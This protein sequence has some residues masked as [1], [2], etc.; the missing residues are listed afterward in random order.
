MTT[1]TS[2]II[3]AFGGVSKLAK[4]L[5]HANVTT[6]DGWKR[7]GR[8]PHWRRLEIVD[9]AKREGVELPQSF[10]EVA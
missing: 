8:I 7:K 3:N 4:A 5:G 6:V 9:A 1:T 10:S 2:E